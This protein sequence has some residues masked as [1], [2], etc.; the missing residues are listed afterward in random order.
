MFMSRLAPKRDERG[1]A[2]VA[3]IA[4]TAVTAI[5]GVTVTAM[6]V[7]AL[8]TTT[9]NRASVESRAAAEAG[10]DV[11]TVGLQT[12][13]SCAGVAGVYS[14]A[15]APKYEAKVQYFAKVS[16]VETWVAGC[17]IDSATR[18]RIVSTGTAQSSGVAGA[19]AGNKTVL[20]ATYQYNPIVVQIPEIN[21]AVYA[22]SINTPLKNFNL[23]SATNA[24]A[25]VQIKDGNVSCTNSAKIAGDL[26]LGHGHAIL[27]TCNVTGTVHVSDYVE[28]SGNG[29]N[30]TGGVIAAAKN[31]NSDGSAVLVKSDAIV[32]GGI[33]AGGTVRVLSKGDVLGSVGVAGDA[34]SVGQVDDQSNIDGNLDSSGTVDVDGTV[35]GTVTEGSTSLVAPDV[36]LIP[37]WTEIGSSTASWVAEG[38]QVT[39]WTGPCSIDNSDPTWGAL[40]SITVKTVVNFIPKCGVNGLT[41]QSNLNPITL[42]ANIAFLADKFYFNKLYLTSSGGPRVLHFI[43]P[44]SDIT[45]GVPTCTSPAGPITFS[46]EANFGPLISATAYTPCKVYS[47][48]DGWRGQIY[49]GEVEFGQQ[50]KLTFVETGIPGFDLTGGLTHPEQQGAEL[51]ALISL[52]EMPDVG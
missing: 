43:V 45:D 32:Q 21:A 5:I 13:D 1:A 15:V 28:V 41:T 4:L 48:R 22:Y 33:L 36:P 37:D 11:A 19:S 31:L 18:V 40:S 39:N 47:D 42:G 6:T 27:N 52:R 3:V 7:N 38:Y 25:S 17:P 10:V 49:G 46:N 2:L 24:L 8:G 14:S 26:I 9:S 12:K 50:A 34:T 29:S 20:E 51:G 16:G 30:V 44:D 23:S 35:G